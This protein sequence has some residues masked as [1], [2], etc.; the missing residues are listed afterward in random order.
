MSYNSSEG[1]H[2]PIHGRMESSTEQ[3]REEQVEREPDEYDSELDIE[4]DKR[5]TTSNHEGKDY[6]ARHTVKDTANELDL[7]VTERNAF[8]IG[9]QIFV[10]ATSIEKDED[11]WVNDAVCRVI[12]VLDE[13]SDSIQQKF[14]VEIF[15]SVLNFET[16][17]RMNVVIWDGNEVETEVEK[18]DIVLLDGLVV[19]T[20]NENKYLSFNSAS[21]LRVVS[22]EYITQLTSKIRSSIRNNGALDTSIRL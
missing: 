3:E 5:W 15:D 7:T 4:L 20:F 16:E 14:R 6:H 10:W 9:Y 11:E 21:S 18:G 17:D 12:E 1:Q 2:D 19:N 8:D 13:D 22:E